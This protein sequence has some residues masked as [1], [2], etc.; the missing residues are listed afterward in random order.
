MGVRFKFRAPGLKPGTKV[1]ALGPFRS[2]LG[3]AWF[4][5]SL[6][7]GGLILLAGYLAISSMAK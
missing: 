5:A 2:R 1:G 6:V 4:I 3:L 7:A